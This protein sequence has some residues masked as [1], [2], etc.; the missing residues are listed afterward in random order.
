LLGLT[1]LDEPGVSAKVVGTVVEVFAVLIVIWVIRTK[2]QKRNAPT[3]T[4]QGPEPY[5]NL[6]AAMAKLHE[7]EDKA[8]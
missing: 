1:F 3:M 6:Q 4:A 7:K 2:R 5:A 8:Q